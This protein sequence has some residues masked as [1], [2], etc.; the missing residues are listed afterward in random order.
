[1]AMTNSSPWD[2]DGFELTPSDK[3]PFA[4]LPSRSRQEPTGAS[5]VNPW[6][7]NPKFEGTLYAL[8]TTL[9][10][11]GFFGLA[12]FGLIVEGTG[13]SLAMAALSSYS[14]TFFLV[15]SVYVLVKWKQR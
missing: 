11:A 3:D 5:R 1:M 2:D 9:G 12:A 15:R 7:Q 8:P 10:M 14:C 4:D 13:F 6:S